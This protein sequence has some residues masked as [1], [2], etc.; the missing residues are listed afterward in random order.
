MSNVASGI[1][2]FDF[3]EIS[4]VSRSPASL[5]AFQRVPIIK[6]HGPSPTLEIRFSIPPFLDLSIRLWDEEVPF[7][8]LVA[9]FVCV[10]QQ[11]SSFYSLV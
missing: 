8:I 2:V 10:V 9:L 1:I 3:Y 4:H 7:L 11:V 6:K 5:T